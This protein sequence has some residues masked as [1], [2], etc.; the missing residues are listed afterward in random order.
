LQVAV[1]RAENI[2]AIV[3]LKGMNDIQTGGNRESNP[4]SIGRPMCGIEKL[5]IGAIEFTPGIGFCI[6]E[7]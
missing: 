5:A 6:E 1:S 3:R 2:N 7:I 4:L